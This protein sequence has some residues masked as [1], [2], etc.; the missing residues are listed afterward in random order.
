MPDPMDMFRRRR[1]S[2]KRK[3]HL[4]LKSQPQDSK[5]HKQVEIGGILKKCNRLLKTGSSFKH[6]FYRF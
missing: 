3:L 6:R 2:R 1:V 4:N 5:V